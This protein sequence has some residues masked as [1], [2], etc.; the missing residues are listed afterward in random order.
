[1]YI[2]LIYDIYQV[3]FY[4]TKQ[5]EC[6]KNYNWGKKEVNYFDAHSYSLDMKILTKL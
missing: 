4:S 6:V 5:N 3:P 2:S 1:M